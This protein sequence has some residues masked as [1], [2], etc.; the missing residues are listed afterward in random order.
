MKPL[1]RQLLTELGDPLPDRKTL[2]LGERAAAAWAMGAREGATAEAMALAVSTALVYRRTKAM[3]LDEGQ[4]M[5]YV[6]SYTTHERVL[7]SL[8][9]LVS[10][11]G[12]PLVLAGTYGLCDFFDVT[13]QLGWRTRAIHVARYRGDGQ[14]LRD[15]ASCVLSFQ[16]HLPLRQQPDLL[17]E[18]EYLCTYT[19]GLI[20][21]LAKWLLRALKLASSEGTETLTHRH[22]EL[23]EPRLKSVEH[24]ALEILNG[25][26]EFDERSADAEDKKR[27]LER[28]EALRERLREKLPV[29]KAT[30]GGSTAGTA[31]VTQ[32]RSGSTVSSKPA[33]KVG[34][35]RPG[36]DPVRES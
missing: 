34:A 31:R 4:L 15:F 23:T 18:R 1:L 32:G 33:Q 13:S 26:R 30:G 10:S 20:G 5:T 19:A 24:M 29:V 7:E 35:R 22:L 28:E 3:F 11:A 9:S 2:P 21:H 25:E 36:R 16:R 8:K 12:I 27:R 17:S 14:D 6:A